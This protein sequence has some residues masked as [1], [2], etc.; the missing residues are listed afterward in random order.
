ML[1]KIILSHEK[2]FE[3][4]YVLILDG[5][6]CGRGSGVSK[7]KAKKTAANNLLSKLETDYTL[8]KNP[9]EYLE[10]TCKNTSIEPQSF[11]EVTVLMRRSNFR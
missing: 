8:K 10:E 11:D 2:E 7:R 1:H 9:V 5:K 3:F 4:T 6:K